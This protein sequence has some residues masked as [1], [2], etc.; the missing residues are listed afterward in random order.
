[1]K[2]APYE[3]PESKK[4]RV[5]IDT[6]CACEADDQYA[7]AHQL[8]TPKFDVRG[9]NA[10][11]FNTMMGMTTVA[12]SAQKS[13]DEVQKVVDLMGLHDT[14]KVHHGCADVLPDEKTPVD[15]EASRFI[16]EEAMRDDERPLFV[17]VQGAITNV[18]SAYLMKPEIAS[19]MTVIWIGGGVYP[20]GCREFNACNDLTAA[21]VIMDSPIELW[22]VPKNVYSMMKVSFATLY[23]K[24]WPYGEIGKYIVENMVNNVNMGFMGNP[25]PEMRE[26]M[27]KM[28]PADMSEGAAHCAYPGGESWQVGDSP[29][30]GLML[31]DHEGHYTVEGAP[32]FAGDGTYLLRPAN[33]R[34]IRVY[35][36]VDNHF[37]LED[38]FAKIKYYFGE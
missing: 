26:M 21:N 31:T 6:D 16:V 4:I 28:R 14:I 37:I 11:H 2:K 12:A 30:V 19:R 36:Y 27:K 24:V 29:V 33:P 25:T 9:I 35:N 38:F 18:A 34:K 17:T 1:M 15:S 20:E 32:R 5:I 7:V 8:M 3:V 10:A 13:F 22:Q 23:D